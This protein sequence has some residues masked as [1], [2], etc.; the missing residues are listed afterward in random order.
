MLLLVPVI[1]PVLALGAAGASLIWVGAGG[2]LTLTFGPLTIPNV[3]LAGGFIAP[4]L[5]ALAF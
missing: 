4:A 5:M 1:G 2:T 3:V